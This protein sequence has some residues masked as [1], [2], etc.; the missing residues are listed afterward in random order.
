M[1][2]LLKLMAELKFVGVFTLALYMSVV[3]QIIHNFQ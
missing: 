3:Y 2:A 1:Y